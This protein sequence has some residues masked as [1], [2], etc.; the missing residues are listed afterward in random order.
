MF[1][2]VLGLASTI[3][4]LAEAQLGLPALQS[5]AWLSN[6][7]QSVLDS[8]NTL[9]AD[10]SKTQ[11]QMQA[12]ISDLLAQNPDLAKNFNAAKDSQDNRNSALQKLKSLFADRSKTASQVEEEST[13][14]F[15]QF[16]ADVQNYLAGITQCEKGANNGTSPMSPGQMS[17]NLRQKRQYSCACIMYGL[18]WLMVS[19]EYGGSNLS[20]ISNNSRGNNV[21]E[22]FITS[23]IDVWC[24]GRSNMMWRM[25]SLTGIGH[26]IGRKPYFTENCTFKNDHL[27]L[28]EY[29]RRLRHIKAQETMNETKNV[30]FGYCMENKT[31][32][33]GDE[34]PTMI[35]AID[36]KY[37]V[38][39]GNYLQCYQWLEPVREEILQ[40]YNWSEYVR[41]EVSILSQNTFRPNMSHKL[42]LHHR[43]GDFIPLGWASKMD[44]ALA[45]LEF[46]YQKIREHFG[47]ISVVIL[48]QDRNFSRKL[49]EEFTHSIKKK[50]NVYIPVFPE[51]SLADDQSFGSL[52]CDSLIIT[53]SSS[54]YAWW[55]AYLMRS[56]K[57]ASAGLIF[58]NS[59]FHSSFHYQRFLPNWIP[60]KLLNGSIEQ[61]KEFIFSLTGLLWT[62]F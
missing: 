6:A 45:A 43:R 27:I 13:A 62:L 41:K 34:N 3:I 10:K 18:L 48:G 53:A 26:V 58:Y 59:E 61:E 56:A 30:E 39:S 49:L 12:A 51:D 14:L 28:P 8:F 19:N 50:P 32:K 11:D 29:V 60:I 4:L 42:C 33:C 20:T 2:I 7:P 35:A 16:P 54:T 15:K 57:N 9:V 40:I 52:V 21:T 31:C 23:R 22:R 55:M 44:F 25:A 37:V 17:T 47:P 36:E 24:G 5:P 46:V 38:L 1:L